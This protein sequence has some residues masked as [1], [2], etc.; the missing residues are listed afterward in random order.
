MI[1]TLDGERLTG[2][3][4]S[5][6]LLG[7]VVD[8]VRRDHLGDRV[9][10]EVAWNGENLVDQSLHERLSEAVPDGDQIDLGSASP[11][12]VAN[13]ALREIAA[14]LRQADAAHR[15]VAGLLQGGRVVD[16]AQ[17]FTG[18]LTVWQDAQR[19]LVEA[20]TLLG[21]DL[22]ARSVDGQTVQEHLARL[23]RTLRE[24]RDAF[25]ARDYV[26]LGD[27]LEFDMPDVCTHWS[28]LFDELAELVTNA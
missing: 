10:V 12:Q 1:V 14:R 19:V 22:S 20:S 6:R 5:P 11:Q 18:L 21:E 15:Q 17:A 23:A 8:R 25:D 3:W 2:D 27:L 9:I 26:L 7:E 16:A 13:D 28:G 24:V 4:G